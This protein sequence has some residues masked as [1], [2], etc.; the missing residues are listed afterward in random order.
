MKI[1]NLN[2]KKGEKQILK[3]LNVEF[4]ENKIHILMG[5][6]GCGKSTLVNTIAG[7]PDCE[8]LSGEILFNSINLLDL[9]IHERALNGIYLSPQYPPVIEG[10][11]H[12]ILLKESLNAKQLFNNKEE[13]DNFQFLKNLKQSAEKFSFDSKNY[14]K[15]SFNS[16]FSGGE[17]KRN[18]ILQ[19]DLLKPKFVF[20]DEIDSGLDIEAMKNIA[21]FIKSYKNL[22]N[23][24]VIIT[25]YPNFAELIEADYFHI[26]KDGK[27][28]QTGG[29][30]L[31]D[32]VILTGF[33]DF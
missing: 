26:M 6:N 12:A 21:H 27:I 28:S 16:G 14:S 7:H 4:E 29:K 32:K 17:K 3:N 10:L 22:G 13:I 15:Q 18:E 9:K 19:I 33:K 25:H 11:S 5:K 2:V 30:E 31:L 24:L 8:V 1:Y 20:M 23:T